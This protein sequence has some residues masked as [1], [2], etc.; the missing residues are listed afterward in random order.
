MDVKAAYGSEQGSGEVRAAHRFDPALSKRGCRPMSGFRRTIGVRAGYWRSIQSD[1]KLVTTG[2]SY[3][4]RRKPPGPLLTGAPAVDRDIASSPRRGARHPVPG[5]W[6]CLDP[7]V[8]GTAF[9]VMEMV[10]GRISWESSFPEV[11]R[12]TVALFRRDESTLGR[13]TASTRESGLGIMAGREI[14]SPGRAAAGR[15]NMRKMAK[16]AGSPPWTGWLNGCRRIF[17]PAR[18]KRA[19]SMATF[20][21]TIWCSIPS[22]PKCSRFSTGN[23]RPLAIRSPTSAII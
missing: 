3:V 23:Y 4:L 20:A 19:S 13:S 6:M 11:S 9:Y 22:A 1:Y 16:Q 5:L 12:A 7:E 8:I 21:A 17:P 15:G 14:I 2:R 10:D 18:M